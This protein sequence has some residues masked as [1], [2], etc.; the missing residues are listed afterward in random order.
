ML[1]GVGYDYKNNFLVIER[2]TSQKYN[3]KI[4]ARGKLTI[5][6]ELREKIHNDRFYI[7]KEQWEE[8]IILAPV[9]E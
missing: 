4:S 9:I 6:L 3:Q 1:K 2:E 7:L 8:K 5:P